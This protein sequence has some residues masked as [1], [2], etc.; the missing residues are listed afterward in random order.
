MTS[1][2]AE[3]QSAEV[4]EARTTAAASVVAHANSAT[5]GSR[6][7]REACEPSSVRRITVACCL[8]SSC[9]FPTCVIVCAGCDGDGRRGCGGRCWSEQGSHFCRC[10][11]CR[12]VLVDCEEGSLCQLQLWH[13]AACKS[14][15]SYANTQSSS[16]TQTFERRVSRRQWASELWHVVLLRATMFQVVPRACRL[17]RAPATWWRRRMMEWARSGL[18]R[19]RDGRRTLKCSELNQTSYAAC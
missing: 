2:A 5:H 8:T 7:V 9:Y 10:G 17:R 18:L 11:L 1:G 15:C 16:G 19:R 3:G 4:G 13:P 6:T 14:L 12:T